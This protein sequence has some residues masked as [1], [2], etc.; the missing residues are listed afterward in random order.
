MTS[1]SHILTLPGVQVTCQHE[2]AEKEQHASKRG[3]KDA[4]SFVMEY[5]KKK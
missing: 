4:A 1:L 2:S 5:G 3:V